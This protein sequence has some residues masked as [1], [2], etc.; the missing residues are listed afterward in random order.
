MNEDIKISSNNYKFKFRVA[1][2]LI[3]DNKL[4]V[5]RI[6]NSDFYFLPGGH[7]R[8]MENTK[9]AILREFKEETKIDTV[10]DRLLF[11]TENFFEG[12]LGNF[13][14]IGFYYLLKPTSNLNLEDYSLVEKD[15]KD[16]L[17]L[18]FKWVNI[19]NLNNFKPEFIK[20]EIKNLSK[21]IKHIIISN[22]EII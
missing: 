4:L 12:K 17:I 19:D 13:H 11:V 16:K 18:D 7:V 6:N 8:L 10:V 1:G 9:D 15:E 2:L 3:I 14:E 20:K 5:V 22:D 21:E